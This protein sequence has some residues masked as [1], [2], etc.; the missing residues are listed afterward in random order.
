VIYNIEFFLLVILN[1]R[2]L[3]TGMNTPNT[4]PDTTHVISR[5][6]EGI[7]LVI[8]TRDDNRASKIFLTALLAVFLAVFLANLGFSIAVIATAA[9]IDY[10]ILLILVLILRLT[11]IIIMSDVAKGYDRISYFRFALGFSVVY[12]IFA[13]IYVSAYWSG[14]IDIN[15]NQVLY[16]E[17]IIDTCAARQYF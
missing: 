17:I 14:R 4:T 16:A 1:T 9:S 11:T 6:T 15:G 12:G 7:E 10:L 2:H 8:Q 13:I 3:H 5:N